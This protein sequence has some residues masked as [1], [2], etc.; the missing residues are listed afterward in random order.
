[1]YK[2]HDMEVE[3]VTDPTSAIVG[4]AS[5]RQ[6]LGSLSGSVRAG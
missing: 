2:R 5:R 3:Q 6:D 4:G 1:M